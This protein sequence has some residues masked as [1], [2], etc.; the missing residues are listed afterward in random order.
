M[1]ILINGRDSRS[2]ER[3][4]E[5]DESDRAFHR[6]LEQE[7]QEGRQKVESTFPNGPFIP[8]AFL[9]VNLD[10]AE[11]IKRRAQLP[12]IGPNYSV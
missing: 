6:S 3:R 9:L 2:V 8:V 1:T 5:I 7:G 12:S 4:D 10:R 11:G